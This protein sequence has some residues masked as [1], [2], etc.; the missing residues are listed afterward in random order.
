MQLIS[1]EL[2]LEKFRRKPATK[3]FDESFAPLR[4]FDERF[5]RQYRFG[6]PSE[7][8]QTSSYTRKDHRL[9]GSSHSAQAQTIPLGFI[10]G[11]YCQ[12]REAP[13]IPQ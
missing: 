10:A 1:P 11:R 3:R 13:F 12:E 9:S 4:M 2:S 7:F 8:P 5:A 6:L